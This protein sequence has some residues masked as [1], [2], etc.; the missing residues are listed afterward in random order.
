[1][2]FV[3]SSLPCRTTRAR[4]AVGNMC[5]RGGVA[6]QGGCVARVKMPLLSKLQIYLVPCHRDDEEAMA[7]EFVG[8]R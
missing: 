2:L 4:K 7:E 8:E 3:I 6:H 5:D 1:M